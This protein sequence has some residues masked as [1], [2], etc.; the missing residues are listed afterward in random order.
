M[1]VYVELWGQ[2]E[3]SNS[4][5]WITVGKIDADS[6]DID[7][8]KEK[9]IKIKFS[10]KGKCCAPA[11]HAK[12]RRASSHRNENHARRSVVSQFY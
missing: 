12:R 6:L 10:F 4:C 7:Y 2:M 1:E 8:L 9:T 11:R 5:N 3:D